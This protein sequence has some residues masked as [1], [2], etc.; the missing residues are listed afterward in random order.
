MSEVCTAGICTGPPCR[1]LSEALQVWDKEVNEKGTTISENWFKSLRKGEVVLVKGCVAGSLALSVRC[2]RIASRPHWMFPGGIKL[3]S[4]K[5]PWFGMIQ[6]LKPTAKASWILKNFVF[7]FENGHIYWF[8][9]MHT[10]AVVRGTFVVV[11][12]TVWVPGI[13][14]SNLRGKHLYDWTILLAQKKWKN[15]KFSYIICFGWAYRFVCLLFF[16]R[17]PSFCGTLM[18]L[19]LK[20]DHFEDGSARSLP[21]IAL[22][23]LTVSPPTFCCL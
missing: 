2:Q 7:K 15:F 21:R 17:S 14:P 22:L 8:V 4:V 1:V 23:H 19:D 3:L 10:H 20:T 12:P 13:E 9:Y 6:S 18:C 11:S 5:K 16:L